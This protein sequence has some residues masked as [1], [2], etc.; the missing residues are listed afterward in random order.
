M[1][2]KYIHIIL[3]NSSHIRTYKYIDP[4]LTRRS[5]C[6]RGKNRSGRVTMN[7]YGQRSVSLAEF[8]DLA[9]PDA[10]WSLNTWPGIPCTWMIYNLKTQKKNEYMRLYWVMLGIT[11]VVS[12]SKHTDL[13]NP[14]S[15]GSH[16][17]WLRI[18]D[19][20][21]KQNMAKQAGKNWFDNA[22]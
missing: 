13:Q 20:T 3:T 14:M 9:M 7:S 11:P 1:Y 4:Q 6:K 5:T 12:Y 16:V 22:W 19:W 15:C 17:E 2:N 10:T 21:C 8:K 18:T